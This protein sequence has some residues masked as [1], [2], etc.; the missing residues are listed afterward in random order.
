MFNYHEHNRSKLA[1]TFHFPLYKTYLS[2]TTG[3][4]WMKVYF[5]VTISKYLLSLWDLLKDLRL[6]ADSGVS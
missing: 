6:T 4:W 3:S 2:Q 5:E 1:S